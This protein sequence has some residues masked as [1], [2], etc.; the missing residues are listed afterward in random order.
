MLDQ[1][2]PAAVSN[3]AQKEIDLVPSVIEGR[4]M[5]KAVFLHIQKTAGSSV[6]GTARHIYGNDQVWSH[7]DYEQRP[8]E[9]AENI[10]FLSGHFG[11]V[12]T[13]HFA[14]RRFAF[15]FLREPMERILSF[16]RYYSST[17]S[18]GSPETAELAQN[19]SRLDFLRQAKDSDL[20]FH[21]E[22]NQ[23]WQLAYGWGAAEV[24]KPSIWLKRFSKAQLFDM[25]AGNIDKFDY[26]GFADRAD[27]DIANI[28]TALGWVAPAVQTYNRHEQRSSKQVLSDEERELLLELTDVDRAV[29]RYALEKWRPGEIEDSAAMPLVPEFR[30][31]EH[32][33]ISI[34][35][36]QPDQ[37]LADRNAIS[38]HDHVR[39][40]YP[41]LLLKKS[42]FLHI[43]ETVDPTFEQIARDIYGSKNV[44]SHA[45]YCNHDSKAAHQVAFLSGH[46]GKVYAE[47]YTARRYSFTFLRDPIDRVLSLYS[48]LNSRFA[49]SDPKLIELAR[50]GSRLDFLKGVYR[51]DLHWHVE[52]VQAWQLV[53][54]W[55]AAFVNKPHAWPR[56]C[57]KKQMYNMAVQALDQMDYVGL[58]ET[59]DEDIVKVFQDLGWNAPI[60]H[61]HERSAAHPVEHKL[62]LQERY[63]LLKLTDVDRKVYRYALARRFGRTAA[64]AWYRRSFVRD[65]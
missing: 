39:S 15:T 64:N 2:E 42:V 14:K 62:S 24:G 36:K 13:E 30:S 3:G 19:R 49:H 34:W 35:S 41:G 33:G 37:A 27:L 55:G 9:E 63:W 7:G 21:L 23:A 22:N 25:A 46:F 59:A 65:Y 31:T 1:K 43:Q 57:P 51:S 60:K 48:Y 28:F 52:N 32:S 61:A 45:D 56:E 4:L 40:T 47:D 11:Y 29:Y 50:N 10:A 53:F 5:K 17:V 8:A 38:S 12:Y 20:R 54:G 18:D 16:H 44:W 58:T 26:V 6:Q